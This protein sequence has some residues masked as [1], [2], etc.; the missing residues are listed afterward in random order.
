MSTKRLRS[1]CPINFS[2]E[3]FGDKWALLIIRD[4]V[5]RG[6][7]TY[8]EFLKSEERVATNILAS[9]LENL[10]A[11]QILR[12]IA[13]PEDGRSSKYILT[14]KGIDL[15]PLLF[16]MMIWSEKYDSKSETRRIPKLMDAIKNE[17]N[18]ISKKAKDRL[19][20]GQAL[21]PEYLG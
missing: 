9:R 2:L 16:E 17:R 7:V 10:E 12:R 19:R 15:L 4:V 14:E 20:S 18:K 21:F 6:K 13:D 8:S 1:H 3:A 11:E 5:F